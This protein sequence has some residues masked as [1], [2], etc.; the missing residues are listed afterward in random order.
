[1]Y[2]R[3][4]HV[5]VKPAAMADL[6]RLYEE[7]VIPT[8]HAVPGCLYASLIQGAL[9]ADECISMTLWETPQQAAA[10]E[11]RDRKSVV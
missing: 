1:M 2:M 8:L 10:Y 3:F 4:V 5:T 6:S 11:R 7:K 9:H